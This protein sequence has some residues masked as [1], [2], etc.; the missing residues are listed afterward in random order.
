L[1]FFFFF[2]ISLFVIGSLISHSTRMEA[3]PLGVGGDSLTV[4]QGLPQ[5]L[6]SLIF[7]FLDNVCCSCFVSLFINTQTYTRQL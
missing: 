2:L 1:V 7:H 6:W 5:E 3:V 4:C